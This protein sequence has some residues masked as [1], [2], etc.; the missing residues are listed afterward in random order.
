MHG[1]SFASLC[2]HYPKSAVDFGP[3]ENAGLKQSRLSSFYDWALKKRY[4]CEPVLLDTGRRRSNDHQI[5][6]LSNTEVAALLQSCSDE[7]IGY[8]W[9]SLGL[10]LRVAEANRVHEPECRDGT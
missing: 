7:L 9:L 3:F 1:S 8:L 5:G 4:L 2:A 10:G 6:T